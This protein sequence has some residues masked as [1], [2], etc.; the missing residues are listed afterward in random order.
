MQTE[1]LDVNITRSGQDWGIPVPFDPEFTIY[2]WFDALLNYSTAIG[3]GV[4]EERFAKWWPA[5][6]HFIGK[7]ITR[8]HCA[9]WPAM[10]FAAGIAPPRS[11]FGHGFVYFKKSEGAAAEKISKSLGN[12]VEPMD[13]IAK[14]SS[15]AFRYYF[16][17]ECPF[18]GDGEFSWER[19]GNVYNAELANNLGNLYSR[20]V[21]LVTKNY[22]SVLAGTANATPAEVQP[23]LKAAVLQVQQHLE[24][25]QYN[26]ALEKVLRSLNDPANQYADRNEPWKLVK[27]DKD[28]TKGILF[29]LLEQLRRVSILL[30]PFLPR[31]SETIYRSFNFTQPW[32]AVRYQDVYDRPAQTEDLRVV[33][34]LEAGK[35]KPLFP[36]IA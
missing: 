24:A 11:V 8:F 13:V 22:D 14:F 2:V 30:K 3:Y 27:T 7:D 23:D 10:C 17:R 9:L 18:P 16:M 20:V 36:R 21:T 26:Q 25:C 19:F 32:E 4:D 15:D 5:D 1:L 34:A 6:V 12:V 33:A 31:S 29:A 35:V 28:A